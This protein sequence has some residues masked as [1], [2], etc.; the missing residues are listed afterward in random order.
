MNRKADFLQ[1]EAIRIDSQNESNRFE[2]RIGML[3]CALQPLPLGLSGGCQL[4]SSAVAERAVMLGGG[5]P[6]GGAGSVTAETLVLRQPADVQALTTN[7]YRLYGVRSDTRL[8]S[9]RP[10]YSGTGE[11]AMLT[12]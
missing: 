2:S 10:S 3:Q 7:S 8:P 5:W 1:N 4:T 12:V 11:P 9:D 6:S